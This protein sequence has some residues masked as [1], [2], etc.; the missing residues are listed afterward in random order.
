MFRFHSFSYRMLSISGWIHLRIAIIIC[1]LASPSY[2][3]PFRCKIYL[4]RALKTCHQEFNRKNVR[5]Q[6]RVLLS[7]RSR[8]SSFNFYQ[9]LDEFLLSF[10]HL[11]VCGQQRRIRIF[12]LAGGISA[13]TLFTLSLSLFAFLFLLLDQT[14]RQLCQNFL[15]RFQFPR[16]ISQVHWKSLLENH[17]APTLAHDPFQ[18]IR[19]CSLFIR[20]E[21]T[22]EMKKCVK[23]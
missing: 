5:F 15:H 18:F 4:Y 14:P 6:Y 8:F 20:E 22:Q 10:G 7:S 9:L 2:T 13:S 3:F 12:F 11:V 1:S 17:N 16:S 21:K 23:K 19:F